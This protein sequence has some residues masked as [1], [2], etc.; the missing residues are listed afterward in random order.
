RPAAPGGRPRPGRP[1]GASAGGMLLV[2]APVVGVI[3][4]GVWGLALVATKR[5][6]AASLAAVAAAPVAVAIQGWPPPEVA[7]VIGVAVMV[8]TRHHENIRRMWRRREP[9]LW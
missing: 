3:L 8:V 1:G 2:L 6:G 5:A 9:A 7:V 4:M